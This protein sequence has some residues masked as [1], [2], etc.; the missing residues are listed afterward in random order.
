[1]LKIKNNE[2]TMLAS[3]WDSNLGRKDFDNKIIELAKDLIKKN[4]TFK[5]IDFN[6]EDESKRKAKTKLKLSAGIQKLN[7]QNVLKKE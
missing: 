4:P 2:Y 6:N 5:D 1:M 3:C 7:Y